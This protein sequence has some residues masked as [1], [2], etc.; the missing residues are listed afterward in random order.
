FNYDNFLN[1]ILFCIET[2]DKENLSLRIKEFEDFVFSEILEPSV[3]RQKLISCLMDLKNRLITK[4]PERE[5]DDDK[6]IDVISPILSAKTFTE[7]IIY[8][9]EILFANLEN[10]HINTADSV[11]VKVIAY[12]KTNYSSD[13]K[14]ETLGELFNCNSA[15]LGKKF[16]KYTGLQFNTYLDNLRIEEAKN[17]LIHTD[18]K[19]YQISKLVG[20]TNTD[21]FFMK[22]KKA[23]GMTPKEFKDNLKDT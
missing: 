16:K 20:Y 9:N 15:Y 2:Y 14:L 23:T 12:I 19:I 4:Y 21:Y 22:F 3:I 18:L 10:F 8:F 11:I 1:K 7:I 5:S 13:L 6:K 17:K